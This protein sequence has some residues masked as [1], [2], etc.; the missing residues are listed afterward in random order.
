MRV[1][2]P[3]CCSL[4]EFADLHH[5]YWSQCQSCGVKI[6]MHVQLGPCPRQRLMTRLNQPTEKYLHRSRSKTY[7]NRGDLWAV[8]DMG[9]C[10]QSPE[11]L[12][13]DIVYPTESSKVDVV[14]SSSIESVL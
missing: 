2:F 4:K 13:C 14:A 11:G 12:V 6:L 7:G 9:I 3:E 1:H 8:Q 5:F 10:S